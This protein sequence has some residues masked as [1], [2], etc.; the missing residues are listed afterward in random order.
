[1]GIHCSPFRVIP[2]KSN[3]NKWRLILDLSC[4]QGMSINDG[5]SR[6]LSSLSYVS[7]DDIASQILSYGQGSIIAKMDVKEATGTSRFTPWTL[8]YWECNGQGRFMLTKPCHLDLRSAPLIFTA[9]ADA[10]QWLMEQCGVSWVR[11]YVDDFI[12]IGPPGTD[13]C[14]R[15]VRLMNTTCEAASVP[16]EPAKNEGPATSITFLGL[17]LDSIRME[18]RLPQDKLKRLKDTVAA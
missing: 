11:H 5:I 9:V 1:M 18:I 10:L 14:S 15:N 13:E 4:P 3:P 12:V 16:I 8:C 7:I 6:E 2:K 17:E